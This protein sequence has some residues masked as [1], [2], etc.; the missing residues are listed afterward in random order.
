MFGWKLLQLG[1]LWLLV[2]LSCLH[3]NDFPHHFL[4]LQVSY[5]H[6]YRYYIILWKIGREMNFV[7]NTQEKNDLKPEYPFPLQ[8]THD[9]LHY[10]AKYT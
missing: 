2:C 3:S 5:K 6:Y 1:K 8:K 10:K 7:E 9:T 4:C